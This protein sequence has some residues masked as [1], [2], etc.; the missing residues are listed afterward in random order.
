[1]VSL[2]N[3]IKKYEIDIMVSRKVS[4]I[5]FYDIKHSVEEEKAGKAAEKAYELLSDIKDNIHQDVVEGFEIEI[6]ELAKAGLAS[7]LNS[8]IVEME[9]YL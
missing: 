1:M 9:G 3:P 6:Y 7:W 4:V 2:K 8:L 5:A